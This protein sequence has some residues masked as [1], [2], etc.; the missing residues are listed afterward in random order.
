MRL[1]QNKLI[2]LTT[3]VMTA[4][5]FYMRTRTPLN[6]R[7]KNPLNVRK[8]N[9]YTWVGQVGESQGFAVFETIEHGFRAAFKTMQTYKKSYGLDTIQGVINRWAPPSD[10]NPTNSYINYVASQLSIS[11][12]EQLR[13]DDYAP[14]LL[15]MSVF[16]GAKGR[17]A[18]TFEQVQNGIALA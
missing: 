17:N 4:G 2:L 9:S 13:A 18:F 8:S 12:S 1:S 7:N 10:N 3:V 5:V 16:E 15:A 6:I 11:P 14:L